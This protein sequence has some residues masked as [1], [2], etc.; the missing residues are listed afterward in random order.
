MARADRRYAPLRGRSCA[1]ATLEVHRVL[2]AYRAVCH[3]YPND[4]RPHLGV[5]RCLFRMGRYGASVSEYLMAKAAPAELATA[6][7]A[8]L[9]IPPYRLGGA[10]AR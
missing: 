2:A 6:I 1:A 5:A 9:Q 7:L 10:F 4:L 8:D 3:R